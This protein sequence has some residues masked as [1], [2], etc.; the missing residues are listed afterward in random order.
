MIYLIN[1]ITHISF[2]IT[3]P[4]T[5]FLGHIY[6]FI[7]FLL[8]S[9]FMTLFKISSNGLSQGARST[10]LTILYIISIIT[11]SY[12]YPQKD[13]KSVYLKITNGDF[14]DNLRLYRGFKKIGIEFDFLLKEK[15]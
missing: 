14:P 4:D 3:Y 5:T 6:L 7:S 10:I 2:L 8:W 15:K 11:T 1:F 12:L 13:G 9:S